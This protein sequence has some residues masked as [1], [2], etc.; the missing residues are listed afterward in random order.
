MDSRNIHP[1]QRNLLSLIKKLLKM[2]KKINLTIL[3]WIS[4]SVLANVSLFANNLENSSDRALI[5]VLDEFS[6]RYNVFFSY[7]KHLVKDISVD[8]DFKKNEELHFA[9]DRLLISLGLSYDTFGKKYIVIYKDSEASQKDLTKLRHH[10]NEI[11]KIESKGNV[12]IV[13]KDKSRKSLSRKNVAQLTAFAAV[14]SVSGTVR[15]ESGEALIGASVVVAGTTNGTTT[16]VDG[17]FSLDVPSFPLTLEI[18]YTGYTSQTLVVNTAR[19]NLDIVLSEGL[20]LNEVIVTSRK[21]EESLQDVPVAITAVSGRKLEAIE[22]TDI[23]SVSTL[24]PNVNFS[25]GGAVSGASSAA[26]VYIRGVGQNDFLQTLDPGV[27]IYIDGVYM[28]RSIGSV[29]DLVDPERVEVLRGPQGSLFGRNTIGGA[30]SLVSKDPG[31]EFEGYIKAIGGDYNRFGLQGSLNIPF[32][33]TFKGR[34]SAKYHRRDGY[35]ERLLVGDDLGSD[36]SIGA[37]ANFLYEPSKK[38]RLKLNFDYTREDETG[39]AEEQLNPNG[40]FA[41]LYNNNILQDTL[42]PD[43]N[44]PDCFQNTI[45]TEEY[46]TNEIAPNFNQVDLFGGAMIGEYDISDALSL[47]SITSYRNLASNFTR[48]SDGSPVVLF[49]TNNDYDQSQFSQELQFT[50]TYDK[51]DFVSGLYF[52]SE[53]GSDFNIVEASDLPF[54][55]TFPL[56]SG[57]DIDNSSFAA[58]GEATFHLTNKFHLTGG[59]RYTT[60]TKRYDPLA[61]AV[62]HPTPDFVT[63]GFREL[64]FSRV[65]WRAIAAYDVTDNINAYGSVSTGFK[66]GGFDARYTGPTT[67]NEPTSFD[68]EEVINYEIGLKTSFPDAGLRLNVAA[69]TADYTNFQV[70]G[71]PPGQIATV[72]FNGAEANIQGLEFEL[73]WAPV[74]GLFINGS[75]GLL[76]GEYVSLNENA[77][78]FTL[79]DKLIRTPTNSYNFGISYLFDIGKSGSLLP[80][81]DLTSQNNIHFEPA[82]NDFVFEDGY[83]H[84]NFLLTYKTPSKKLS[85]TAGVLNLTNQRYL[86]SGDSNGV[87]SYALG[88]YSRPRNW[89]A[90]VR[91]DF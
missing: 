27:G 86:L 20:N 88:I 56:E 1:T 42:C 16:D 12:K 3:M 84:I 66:S 69:F 91:Y 18:S 85:I 82:N 41:N 10:F 39:A 35:V 32:S 83:Q 43:N 55:P 5:E 74:E 75:L 38:F 60:E 77:N 8:F 58:F 61:F 4:I 68:P 54:I 90:S 21:R 23:S 33:K 47:R 73:D 6:E 44:N 76:D 17:K 87:L 52:F 53:Q 50:G 11:E 59:L 15:D 2:A 71:N 25:F 89:M 49:Q 29:L 14:E 64:D 48:G 28:G 9:L 80:R 67:D 24:A 31:D 26:V 30:I 72:T 57:G 63:R 81:F 78:E 62:N 46:T 70:Q 36:N 37:R 13:A 34:V 19:N 51:V 65:T 22:A 7:E 45:S 40:V 79:D